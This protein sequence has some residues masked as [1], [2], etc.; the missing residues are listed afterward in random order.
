MKGK[1][2][3][4]PMILLAHHAGRLHRVHAAKREVVIYDYGDAEEPLLAKNGR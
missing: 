3:L 2:K 4:I 1:D